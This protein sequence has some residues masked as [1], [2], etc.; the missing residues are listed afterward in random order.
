MIDESLLKSNFLGRDGFRWW[1]GQVAPGEAQGNQAN[2][3]GWGNR[4]KV[5]IL[6]YHPY[7]ETELSND[8][9]PWAQIL[10][11][12]TS[13]DGGG[14]CA[15]STKIKPGSV[16]F[17]FF[18]DGD[19]AQIPVVVGCFGRT[20]DIPTGSEP[21][22]APFTPFTGYTSRVKKPNGT[23]KGDESN[24]N[25]AASQKSPRDVPPDTIN[26]LN[27]ENPQSGEVPY[28]TG[29]G[30]VIVLGNSCSDTAL[31]G[32]NAEIGNLLQ[33]VQSGFDVLDVSLE[34]SK[35]VDK[36][37]GIMNTYVGKMMGSL[38]TELIPILQ[39]GLRLLYELVKAAVLAATGNE[40]IAHL[41]G[42]AAQTAMIPPVKSL[43]DGLHTI[44]GTVVQNLAGS[45]EE[46]LTDL[47]GNVENFSSCA[48]V[49]FSGAILNNTIDSLLGTMG[50]LL[51]GVDKLLSLVGFDPEAFLR[52]TTGNIQT[53]GGLFDFNQTQ[54]KCSGI[55]K[56][57]VIGKGIVDPGSEKNSFNNILKDMNTSISLARGQ[58]TRKVLPS[59]QIIQ[60]NLI[61]FSSFTRQVSP[62]DNIVY[63][64]NVNNLTSGSFLSFESEI[65]KVNSIDVNANSVNVTRAY[66]GIVTNYS[67]GASV[68]IVRPIPEK[69]L[70]IVEEIPTFDQKYGVWDI[71]G[72]SSQ[73]LNGCYTGATVLNF[74]PPSVKIFGGGGTGSTGQVI[75]GNIVNNENSNSIDNSKTASIIGVDL[76]NGGSNYTSPPFVEFY[77]ESK[78]GY[79]AIGRAIIDSNKDSKTYGQVTGIYMAS[80]G[81]NYP[82]GNQNGVGISTQIYGVVSVAVISQGN[83]YS[84]S[85]VVSDN[86]GNTYKLTVDK[87]NNG[88][89]ISV[90]VINIKRVEELPLITVESDT[91]VGA[92]LKPILGKIQLT[93]PAKLTRIVD[94]PI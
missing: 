7:S 53:I 59:D 37:T 24:E 4:C 36:I 69:E 41:A 20:S 6:G 1:I 63:L 39:Q 75:L 40:R 21:Y 72:G 84:P 44:G 15:T 71:F 79:G 5:R 56:E 68:S 51:G 47:V 3:G 19:N 85:D 45:V 62:S 57:W 94:C 2:G 87:D 88:K 30:K 46:L 12:T 52:S 80:V 9:L 18:L 23:L 76:Q 28:F 90:E 26:K 77:D 74:S 13:G 17:G 73:S 16:V 10:L 91:G 29:I 86:F 43:E 60:D 89:I 49:Q 83:N 81:E 42:V 67:L 58:S 65:M 27:Q 34:I 31:S 82:I 64:Q 78:Q 70:I 54:G 35:S 22:V 14:G 50:P 93:P 66:S 38:Y 25:N 33:K 61:S 32:T 11:P 8:D 48:N 55:S 92:L